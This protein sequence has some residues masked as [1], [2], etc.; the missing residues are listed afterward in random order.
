[1]TTRNQVLSLAASQIGYTESGGRDGKSGN[2]TKYWAALKP[3]WQGGPWCAT[4]VNWVLKECGSTLLL[5]SVP[6]PYYTPSMEA[7]AKKTGRWKASKDCK[8]GDVLIFGSAKG[9]THTGFLERQDGASYV[10]AIEGNTSPGAS[11]SQTNGGGVYRR[12][13]PRSWVR[14]CIDLSS[15]YTNAPTVIPASAAIKLTQPIK[16]AVDGEL[17]VITRGGWQKYQNRTVTG[18]WGRGDIRS[19]QSWV[20]RERTGRLSRDDIKAIQAKLGFKGKDVDGAWGP[21]TTRQFQRF[22][23]RRFEEA[24]KK[25]SEV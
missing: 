18:V 20:S 11:G 15:E 1:M 3:T 12:R 7:W 25:A 16:L 23:N 13:R 19:L 9:A 8:P 21:K 5:D 17:G 2:I 24:F 22:L 6:L 10:I 4:F 14:G